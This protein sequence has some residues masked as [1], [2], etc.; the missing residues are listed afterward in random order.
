MEVTIKKNIRHSDSIGCADLPCRGRRGIR[1]SNPAAVLGNRVFLLSHAHL[2]RGCLFILA[3]AGFLRK[4][5]KQPEP[6]KALPSSSPGPPTPLFAR[7]S[8]TTT[9]SSNNVAPR[10]VSS[11]MSLAS[12]RKDPTPKRGNTASLLAAGSREAEMARRRVQDQAQASQASLSHRPIVDKPLPSPVVDAPPPAVNRR[13]MSNKG[14]GPPPTFQPQQH[15]GMWSRAS[16]DS[17]ERDN[18]PLPRP[19]SAQASYSQPPGYNFTPAVPPKRVSSINTT[20]QIAPNVYRKLQPPLPPPPLQSPSTDDRFATQAP[21]PSKRAQDFP[22]SDLPNGVGGGQSNLRVS[23]QQPQQTLPE[24]YSSP[25]SV[26]ALD[27]PPEFAL[28]QVSNLSINQALAAFFRLLRVS[29]FH[30]DCPQHP[31]I[32]KSSRATLL[33]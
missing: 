31:F 20:P 17:R 4:K 3:M 8:S 7:F 12:G 21:L 23:Q 28:F 26:H 29:F 15:Q 5:T 30:S 32:S 13:T 22:S 18:K 10:I 16:L 1:A 24:I 33:G 2:P 6:T 25:L 14:P 19:G 27:L 9:N 11:P